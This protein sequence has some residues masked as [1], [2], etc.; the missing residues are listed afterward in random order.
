ADGSRFAVADRDMVTLWDTA[1]GERIAVF[2]GLKPSEGGFS[3]VAFSTDGAEI[4]TGTGDG[5]VRFWNAETGLLME[6]LDGPR[7]SGKSSFRS[8]LVGFD[9]D[10]ATF[11]S[12]Q[13]DGDWRIRLWEL[14]TGRILRDFELA[15]CAEDCSVRGIR[16]Y[17]GLIVASVS[18]DDV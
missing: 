7:L 11:V 5:R 2:E 3:S 12:A 1:S 8:N 13:G 9:P 15:R 14:A 17:G 18:T 4:A 10:G 6:T 16:F